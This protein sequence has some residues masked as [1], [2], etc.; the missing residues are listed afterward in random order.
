MRKKLVI[1]GG[2]FAGFWSA[3]SAVRQSLELI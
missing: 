1:I 3:M 2:G